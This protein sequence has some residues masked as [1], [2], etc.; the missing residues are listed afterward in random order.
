VKGNDHILVDFGMTGPQALLQTAGLSPLDIEVVCPT[1]SHAD[2]IGGLEC[3]ALLNR[4]V[5]RKFF[6][7]PKT[8]M[9]ITEEYQR[10]LWDNS[11]RGGL[12]RNEEGEGSKA[13]TFSDYFGI[14]RPRWKTHQPRETFEVVVGGIKLELFRTKHIPDNGPDWET[15]FISYGM[16]IDDRIFFSGDTRFDEDLIEMY[17]DRSEIMFHDVQFFLGGV[18]A[19]LANLRELPKSVKEKMLLMHYADDWGKQ[20]ISGFLGFAKQ[21]VRYIF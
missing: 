5:G 21:G 14:I 18:H 13:M 8:R 6:N 16:L 2:H 12:E 4:Y 10:I 17:K 15:S 1:H 9:I 7:K 3:L 19:P 20:D 11:L